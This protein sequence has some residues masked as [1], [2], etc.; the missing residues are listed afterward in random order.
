MLPNGWQTCGSSAVEAFRFHDGRIL[1]IV[2]VQGRMVYDYPC[3]EQL[4]AAFLRATS[5]G[6]FVNETLKPYGARLGWAGRP[7]RWHGW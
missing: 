5:K 2:F 3:T 7:Y 6:R 1:Q 4:Y